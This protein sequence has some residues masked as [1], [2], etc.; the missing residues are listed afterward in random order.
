MKHCKGRFSFICFQNIGESEQQ[1]NFPVYIFEDKQV[2]DEYIDGCRDKSSQGVQ[3]QS[4]DWG[5][6]SGVRIVSS[7]IQTIYQNVHITLMLYKLA[8][9]LHKLYT[10]EFNPIEYVLLNVNQILT[11]HQM[12]FY[13]LNSKIFKVGI[14]SLSNRF[15]L[16]NNKIPLEWLSL[17]LSSSKIKCKKLVLTN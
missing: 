7:S 14:N 12:S 16:L 17:S 4:S 1:V 13:T 9:C 10:I 3:Y 2:Q 15:N 6:H 8:L 5:S 11:S